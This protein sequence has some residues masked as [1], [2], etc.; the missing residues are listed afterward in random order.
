MSWLKFFC[1]SQVSI[2]LCVTSLEPYIHAKSK[3]LAPKTDM[4]QISSQS[5]EPSKSKSIPIN[6][7]YKIGLSVGGTK[8]AGAAVLPDGSTLSSVSFAWRQVLGREATVDD[9]INAIE[10]VVS[11]IKAQNQDL[12][13]QGIGLSFPGP[14][15]YEKG[16]FSPVNLPLPN[17]YP[18]KQVLEERLGTNVETLHDGAAAVLGE[19][20]P[21]GTL[22]G[23][24]DA[25]I[26]ILGT[27]VG[28]GIKRN[29]KHDYGK[30]SLGE[31]GWS[32]WYEL[33]EEEE[34]KEIEPKEGYPFYI[35]IGEHSYQD[36]MLKIEELK[37]KEGVLSIEQRLSGPNLAKRFIEKTILGGGVP[38][39]SE[40]LGENVLELLK[41]LN[42]GDAKVE[43][44]VLQLITQKA[45][46]PDDYVS[47]QFIK[48]SG[49]EL[50][51][52]LG[53]FFLA[54][55]E[56]AF[57]QHVVLVS[58]VGEN[59]GKG[60]VTEEGEDLWLE[61][62]RKGV[63]EILTPFQVDPSKVVL[64]SQGIVRSKMS[65]EREILAFVPTPKEPTEVSQ[66]D[67]VELS[68]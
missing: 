26:V 9:F 39:S 54:Y 62:I 8:I 46:E 34:E 6:T 5:M 25:M 16:F 66:T 64:I 53:N 7:P 4:K 56:E 45:Q 20:S 29:G 37:S 52:A 22:P 67:Q 14:G 17:Q 40:Y 43:K 41:A 27:G 15:E 1:F 47:L 3:V 36:F 31:L 35:H 68:L 59:F 2:F 51:I 50:G 24:E 23:V 58:G 63:I 55:I 10:E 61:Y 48:D 18:I 38:S 12:K 28:G 33:E 19:T 65:H 21:K 57:I 44:H 49:F 13:L 11:Q 32:L 60:V 30:N 42:K